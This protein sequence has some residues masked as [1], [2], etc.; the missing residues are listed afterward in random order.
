MSILN[1]PIYTRAQITRAVNLA[2]L[3]GWVAV[4]APIAFTRFD[5]LLWFASALIGLPIAFALCW[6]IGAPILRWVL[7]KKVSWTAAAIWGA[8]IAAL[9]FSVYCVFAV[10]GNPS[11][12]VGG[13]DYI[14]SVNG[15]LTPYG[16]RMLAVDFVIFVLKGMAIALAVRWATGPGLPYD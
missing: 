9:V 11:S 2:A 16:W 12:Q 13:G 15:V 6:L 7:Q 1:S 14:I 10:N 5:P 8:V 4:T 3:M